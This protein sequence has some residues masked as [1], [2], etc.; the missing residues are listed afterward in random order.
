MVGAILAGTLL[1]LRGRLL[2]GLGL[3]ASAILLP[4]LVVILFHS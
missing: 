4:L 3:C 1:I 2:P